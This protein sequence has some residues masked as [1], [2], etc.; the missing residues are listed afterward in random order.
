[1][2]GQACLPVD[3]DEAIALLTGIAVQLTE[4]EI[5]RKAAQHDL[6]A[7]YS[8]WKQPEGAGHIH[9]DSEEWALMRTATKAEFE[10]LQGEAARAYSPQSPL[11]RGDPIG[12]G[13]ASRPRRCRAGGRMT[14][15]A[16]VVP[17]IHTAGYPP[18]VNPTG[19]RITDKPDFLDMEDAV[20]GSREMSDAVYTLVERAAVHGSTERDLEALV[21]CASV[22]QDYATKVLEQW[23][24]V[25]QAQVA[26]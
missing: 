12:S 22:A 23:N 20:R 18:G 8:R 16:E 7:A 25:R 6:N 24:A 10:A 17:G 2:R 3:D 26:A 15:S 19:V 5:G 9:R 21:R 11:R 4:A 1:M 14:K 13:P